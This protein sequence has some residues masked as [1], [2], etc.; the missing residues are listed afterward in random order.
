VNSFLRQSFRWEILAYAVGWAVLRVLYV[1]AN[2]V[3]KTGGTSGTDL[4]GLWWLFAIL[5]F[6]GDVVLLTTVI[7]VRK[8]RFEMSFS[9]KRSFW[10]YASEVIPSLFMLHLAYLT[11]EYRVSSRLDRVGLG[12]LESIVYLGAMVMI[13]AWIFRSFEIMGGSGS[14]LNPSRSE[15]LQDGD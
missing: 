6:I 10:H 9:P 5:Y 3:F 12:S 4:S 8:P 13:A 2:S 11:F 7:E 14:G 1:K 15:R